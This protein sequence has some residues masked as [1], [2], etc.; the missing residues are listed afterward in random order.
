MA[1]EKERK[2]TLYP[3]NW[4]YNAG[5]VGFLRVLEFGGKDKVKK[6]LEREPFYIT[7]D[8]IKIIKKD[9]ISFI[10]REFIPTLKKKPKD[11]RSI[12][13]AKTGGLLPNLQQLTEYGIKSD[14]DLQSWWNKVI[15]NAFE[16]INK[17]KKNAIPLKCKYCSNEF[18]K[19][20]FEVPYD[21]WD[22]VYNTLM[23]TPFYENPNWFFYSQ[24][25]LIFCGF[26]KLIL[27]LSNFIISQRTEL[28]EFI[29]VP[30]I[31]A[32]Y[33]LNN[34]L[35]K[36]KKAKTY[37]TLNPNERLESLI[38]EALLNYEFLKGAWLLQNVEFIQIEKGKQPKVYTLTVSRTSAELIVRDDVRR[39]LGNLK[40][41]IT[42]VKK[43]ENP[44][45]VNAQREG[46]RKF[47]AGGEGSLVDLAYF[48]FKNDF[49]ENR[50]NQTKETILNLAKLEKIKID[51]KK[52]KR[53]EMVEND[54]VEIWN[55]G[56]SL[57]GG[58]LNKNFKYELLSASLIEDKD[59][60]LEYLLEIE[61][62]N[63]IAGKLAPL[64]EFIRSKSKL[65]IREIILAFIAGYSSDKSLSPEDM[66]KN[67]LDVFWN[68]GQEV[69]KIDRDIESRIKKYVFRTISKVRVGDR[70]GAIFEILKLYLLSEK[71][72]PTYLS[73]IFRDTT[74][75]EK[76][77]LCAY[78]FIAGFMGANRSE[79]GDLMFEMRKIGNSVANEPLEDRIKKYGHRL[80]SLIRAGQRAEFAHEIIKLYA[81]ARLEIPYKFIEI[82][83]PD[84]PIAEFQSLAFGIL[85]GYLE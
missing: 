75:I 17:K 14:A 31:K 49:M 41:Q 80:L 67:P 11:I 20:K 43:R 68:E 77:K 4:L 42:I 60:L 45:K 34:L 13:F 83:D 76:F 28:S 19:D 69:G 26:C 48:S 72:I 18:Y 27:I 5:V 37:K 59:R 30:S 65:N 44:I 15:E 7:K 73:E 8:E 71:P 33:Y 29:N 61:R 6:V 1:V 78:S 25:D 74:D 12:L 23:P 38:S 82:L 3:S 79:T 62:R 22:K 24:N 35:L 40:G 47:L 10:K 9:F 84:K 66:S 56:Q 54:L 58:N 39:V 46:V 21:F 52:E 85:S 55:K 51:Y 36:L 50:Y 64:R 2:I 16:E 63:K 53:F 57:R 70:N 81:Q 32:L